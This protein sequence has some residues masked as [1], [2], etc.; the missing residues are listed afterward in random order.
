MER[1][2]ARYI[3]SQIASNLW[4]IIFF[5][6]VVAQH[7]SGDFLEYAE[8]ETVAVMSCALG[9]AIA[10]VTKSFGSPTRLT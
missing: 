7:R 4:K 5:G 1:L 9:L 8:V 10:L 6:V 3:E 2:R